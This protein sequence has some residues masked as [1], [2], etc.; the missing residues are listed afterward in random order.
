MKNIWC[1]MTAVAL[2][3][4]CGPGQKEA[5]KDQDF[6]TS[7]NKE[8]D[9]R[10]DQRMAKTEEIRGTGGAGGETKASAKVEPGENGNVL[11]KAEA[12]KSLFDRLGG[13][14]GIAKVVD[15][16]VNRAMA[17]PRVNWQRKGVKRGGLGLNRNDA[18]E[19]KADAAAVAQLK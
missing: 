6:F 10:A 11:P 3:A 8:A 9:Q 13:Q 4:G 5:R 1:I 15:D 19:W 14:E 18:V 16:F 12:V 2:L 17:D 7:G